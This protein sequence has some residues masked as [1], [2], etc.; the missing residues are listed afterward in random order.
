MSAVEHLEERVHCLEL[1]VKDLMVF[2]VEIK[3]FSD[4]HESLDAS[5]VHGGKDAKD[6][7]TKEQLA[8]LANAA[9]ARLEAIAQRAKARAD[10]DD[11]TVM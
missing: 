7:P 10:A 3:A 8:A 5:Q 11:Q 4:A 2:A 9:T 6:F 1:Q